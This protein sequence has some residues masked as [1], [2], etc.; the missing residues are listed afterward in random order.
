[1][2][3]ATR[4]LPILLLAAGA[5]SRM[6]GGDKL[7]EM[8]MGAPCVHTMTARASATGHAVYVTLP[9]A[10]HP[11]SHALQGLEVHRVFVPDAS[12]GMSR[13]LQKGIAALPADHMGAMILPADMP[14]ITTEDMA[15]M[16]TAFQTHPCDALQAS[17][18]DGQAGH[19]T[20]L[21]PALTRQVGTLA[22]DKGAASL[23]KAAPDVRLHPLK[24]KRARLDLD[25]PE[26]WAAWR[27]D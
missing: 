13:S 18:Q 6:R 26:D 24:G 11:R 25:T 19:P 5:S 7:M 20:I 2:P 14:D 1:M 3:D 27:G 4:P 12:A 16:L 22:G 8:V 17:T 10:D 21:G 23:I 9:N 15:E